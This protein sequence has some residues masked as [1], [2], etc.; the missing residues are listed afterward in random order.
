MLKCFLICFCYIWF[1][2]S[3][4]KDQIHGLTFHR[5]AGSLLFPPFLQRL[6]SESGKVS[7]VRCVRFPYTTCTSCPWHRLG[8]ARNVLCCGEFRCVSLSFSTS[9]G[10]SCPGDRGPDIAFAQTWLWFTP[11]SSARSPT[12]ARCWRLDL[13]TDLQ[14][15]EKYKK[16]WEMQRHKRHRLQHSNLPEMSTYR[17]GP[18]GAGL[19]K[20]H[21]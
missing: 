2:L 13:S 15:I 9:P 3:A 8:R 5:F 21:T 20:G 16:K 7:V 4:K 17:G 10:V 14:K 1:K 6:L 11:L 18:A 12:S 19:T